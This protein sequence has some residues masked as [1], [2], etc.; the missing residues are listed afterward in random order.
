MPPPV[1]HDPGTPEVV[2]MPTKMPADTPTA[3]KTKRIRLEFLVG[4]TAED[5]ALY[6]AMI[7]PKHP[8]KVPI[9]NVISDC[10]ACN[11][12]TPKTKKTIR[13]L[14]GKAACLKWAGL[15]D[16]DVVG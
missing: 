5:Q 9:D 7:D 2:L 10:V 13:R 15:G 3:S 4:E 16:S 8:L 11:L 12:D 14:H 1:P 6:G